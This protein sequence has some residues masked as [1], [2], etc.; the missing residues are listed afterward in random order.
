MLVLYRASVNIV[1]G[2]YYASYKPKRR[3]G[4]SLC[5]LMIYGNQTRQLNEERKDTGIL[6]MC[7]Y[8]YVLLKKTLYIW[9]YIW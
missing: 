8:T 5:P 6:G 7:L 9:Y 4:G 3:D 2:R 1:S